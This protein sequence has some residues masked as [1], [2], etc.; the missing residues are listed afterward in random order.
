MVDDQYRCE[1][2]NVSPG[3]GSPGQSWTKGHK[4][5]LVV[6]AENVGNGFYLCLFLQSKDS[7]ILI[8]RLRLNTKLSWDSLSDMATNQFKVRKATNEVTFV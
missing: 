5:V 1:W 3:T 4:K 7:N 8:G 6:V 2:V